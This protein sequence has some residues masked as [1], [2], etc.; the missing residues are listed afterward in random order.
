MSSTKDVNNL[1][2][3]GENQFFLV[4]WSKN[5]NQVDA[6]VLKP[7]ATSKLLSPLVRKTGGRRHQQM[8][9]I[10][11]QSSIFTSHYL[12]SSFVNCYWE[13]WRCCYCLLTVA[14]CF[15][16][17][18][19]CSF[20]DFPQDS[21]MPHY[22]VKSGGAAEICRETGAASRHTRTHIRGFIQEAWEVFHQQLLRITNRARRW[23]EEKSLP[24]KYLWVVYGSEGQKGRQRCG[25]ASLWYTSE[26][27]TRL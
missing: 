7:I 4:Q 2:S 8:T 27:L 9:A 10:S 1:L 13:T 22:Q 16:C 24:A 17:T 3:W 5:T 21:S 14:V 18:V 19:L 25:N 11:P 20:S 26:P 12:L 23:T 15:C 6:W